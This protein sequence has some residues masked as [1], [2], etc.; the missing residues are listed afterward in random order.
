MRNPAARLGGDVS[1]LASEQF[2]AALG[3]RDD[4][5]SEEST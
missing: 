5:R 2:D 4:E 1:E 3:H